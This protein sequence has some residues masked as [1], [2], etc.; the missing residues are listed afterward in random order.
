M[1]KKAY[2]SPNIWVV[3]VE[4]ESLIASSPAN[5]IDGLFFYTGGN[6]GFNRLPGLKYNDWD[7]PLDK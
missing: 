1:E 7:N 5:N 3:N 6:H 4:T 2:E